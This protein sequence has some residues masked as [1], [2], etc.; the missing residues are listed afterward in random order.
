MKKKKMNTK[1]YIFAGAFAAMYIVILLAAVMIFGFNPILYLMIPLLAG[2]ILGPVFI[3][4]ISKVPKKG[5][6]LILSILS[7]LFMS[8]YSFIPLAIAVIAGVIAEVVLAN[9]GGN[10]KVKHVIAYSI[11]NISLIGPFTLLIFARDQF[12]Q[13]SADYYGEDYVDRIS[14]LTPDWIL[15]VLVVLA[16]V[17]GLI[18]AMLGQKLNKKHFEQAGIV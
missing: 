12:M 15:I 6:I 8:S 13:T 3:L 2:I 11:F 9:R 18:G 14:A 1:D 5:A 7:G 4:Y 16:I 10:I 17:G